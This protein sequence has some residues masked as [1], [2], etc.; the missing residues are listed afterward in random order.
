MV[1]RPDIR[2]IF[3]LLVLIGGVGTAIFFAL[4]GDFMRAMIAG[5]I[6]FAALY[7]VTLD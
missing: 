3:W 2:L 5:T 7:L 1:A 6:A 4:A